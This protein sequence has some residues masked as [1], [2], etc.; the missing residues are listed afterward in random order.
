MH[1]DVTSEDIKTIPLYSKTTATRTCRPPMNF[2]TC[3][4]C[5]HKSKLQ[6]LVSG[7]AL[8]NANIMGEAAFVV[9]F[10]HHAPSS[11]W[12]PVA[13]RE[14]KVHPNHLTVAWNS[15]ELAVERL[16]LRQIMRDVEGR[17]RPPHSPGGTSRKRSRVEP[18][19]DSLEEKED[20]VSSLASSPVPSSEEE[21][22]PE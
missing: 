12:L 5:P 17:P 6:S 4:S 11:S 19:R 20:D 9:E 3:V 1:K 8:P 2:V 22:E 7:A 13:L 10:R 18:L 14:D 15:L 16:T 21:R